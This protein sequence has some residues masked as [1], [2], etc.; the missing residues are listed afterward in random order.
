MDLLISHALHV[1]AALGLFAALGSI[2]LSDRSAR[3]ATILHGVSLLLL[4][5]L[6]FHLLFAKDLVKSGGWWHTKVLLWLVLGA[7]PALAK[8]KVMPPAALLGLCLVLG[9]AAAFLGHAKIF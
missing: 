3:G 4:I 2:C 5:G 1:T 6:G 8:R 7:A 9:A